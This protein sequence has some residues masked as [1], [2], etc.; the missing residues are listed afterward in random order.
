[1]S[2]FAKG[3]KDISDCPSLKKRGDLEMKNRE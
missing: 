3:G 2:P 1:M